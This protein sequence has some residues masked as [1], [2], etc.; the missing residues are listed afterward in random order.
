MLNSRRAELAGSKLDGM[1]A[2]DGNV[3]SGVPRTVIALDPVKRLTA[4]DSIS[5]MNPSE[6]G[7]ATY[8]KAREQLIDDVRAVIGDTEELLKALG[9]ESKEKVAA[10]RPRVEAGLSRARAQVAE[11]EAAAEAR[12]RRAVHDV[13]VYAHDNPWKTAGVAAGVGA[14]LGA[15]IGVLLARH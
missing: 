12:A 11:L 7:M 9:S 8:S 10:V 15:I 4:S 5:I 3:G 14:A 6:G 1:R 2:Q 13:D